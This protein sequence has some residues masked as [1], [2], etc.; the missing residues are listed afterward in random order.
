VDLSDMTD[1]FYVMAAPN[2]NT[3]YYYRVETS[4]AGGTSAWSTGSFQTTA[5]FV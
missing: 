2:S 3:S 4:N 5:P 1:A